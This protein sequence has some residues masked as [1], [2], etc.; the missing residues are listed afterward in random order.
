MRTVFCSSARTGTVQ[1]GMTVPKM[2]RVKTRTAIFG[3]ILCFERN[4]EIDI[5]HTLTKDC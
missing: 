2:T 3:T 5:T 4:P 1:K